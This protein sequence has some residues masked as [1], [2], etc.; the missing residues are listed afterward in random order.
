M[1]AAINQT[2]PTKLPRVSVYMEPELKREIEKLANLEDRSVG[3]MAL[4]LI[5]EALISRA[6]ATTQ[7]PDQARNSR[8]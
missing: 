3:K 1:T 8:G 7:N 2:V 5:K 6:D 4:T